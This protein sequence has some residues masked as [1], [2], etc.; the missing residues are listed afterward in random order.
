MPVSHL[1]FGV[2]CRIITLGCF[3]DVLIIGFFHN[4]VAIGLLFSYQLLCRNLQDVTVTFLR[5]EIMYLKNEWSHV[6]TTS[7]LISAGM[8]FGCI[9]GMH[10]FQMNEGENDKGIKKAVWHYWHMLS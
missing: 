8:T 6:L 10:I 1:P 5:D 7:L 2:T 3:H 9:F 4:V